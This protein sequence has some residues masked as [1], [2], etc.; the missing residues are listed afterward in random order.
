M[1]GLGL[2]NEQV[3]FVQYAQIWCEVVD[4]EGYK[5]YQTESHSPGKYR[6]NGALQ[7]FDEFSKAFHCPT[8]S[9][10]NPEKKCSLWD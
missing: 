6:S 5:K 4:E 3:F 10:M 1:P 2:S 9:P 8:G 7:N